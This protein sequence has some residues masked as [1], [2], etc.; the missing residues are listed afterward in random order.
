MKRVFYEASLFMVFF[1]LK[2]NL[3]SLMTPFS[4]YQSRDVTKRYINVVT[5]MNIDMVDID[6]I[7][8][9]QHHFTV[10]LSEFSVQM[11]F[12]FSPYP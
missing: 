6:L 5:F 10:G 1:F 3:L 12:K 11:H 9:I 7:P 2:R 4:R 8:N